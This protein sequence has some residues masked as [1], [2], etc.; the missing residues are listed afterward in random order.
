MRDVGKTGK[1]PGIVKKL[2]ERI[3]MDKKQESIYM[4]SWKYIEIPREEQ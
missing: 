3:G 2:I 1:F 4:Q